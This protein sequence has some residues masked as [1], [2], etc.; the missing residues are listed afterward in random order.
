MGRKIDWSLGL[1]RLVG[2]RAGRRILLC[3]VTAAASLGRGA[4][5]RPERQALDRTGGNCTKE[6]VGRSGALGRLLISSAVVL[7][8][9]PAFAQTSWTNAG[10]GNWFVNGNWSAGTPPVGASTTVGNGGTAQIGAAANASSNLAI[11]NGSTVE[12]D[13]GGSLTASNQITVDAT[14]T[15]LLNGSTAVSTSTP[16]TSFIIISGTLRSTGSGTVSTPSNFT[17]F[18]P[19]A[20]VSVAT[21]Q[22]LNFAPQVFEV[23]SGLVKF[24][25]AT[26]A[27]TI[28][29]SSTAAAA[30][31]PNSSIEVVNGTVKALDSLTLIAITTDMV[32]TKVDVGAVLDLNDSA[33]SGGGF[34]PGIFNLVG[35][36]GQ[37]KI[38]TNA[39]TILNIN[40]GN[41]AGVISGAGGLAVT[42]VGQNGAPDTLILTGN[43]TYAGGV[44]GTT[45]DALFT[46]QLG[47]GGSSGSILGNVI[48]NGMLIFDRSDTYVF[49]G[50]IGGTGQVVQNGTGTTVIS[51]DANGYSGGTVI[52]A[53]TLQF[54]NGGSSGNLPGD[55]LD[56]ATLA[57]DHSN[58]YAYGG[59]ISGTG[60]VTQI[61]S[62]TLTLSGAN[63]YSGGTTVA[64][65]TLSI[66]ADNN[67]GTGPVALLNG[68]TLAF[69][70][71]FTYTHPTT[72]AGMTSLDVAPA[73]VVTISSVLAD[74]GS[75]GELVKI[76][77][78]TLALSGTNTYSGGT[79]VMA[80][81]LSLTNG[82]AI[83]T[84]LLALG[85]GTTLDL[86]GS[87]TLANAVTI[88]GDPLFNVA[89]GNSSTLSGVI[90]DGPAP[91]GVVEKTGGGTLTLTGA[92]TYSGG[93]LI[94][95]GTLVGSSTSFGSGAILDNGALIFNQAVNGSF[96]AK[97][98]GTG[99]VTKEGAGLL[100]LTGM[101]LYTGP[102]T[103]AAGTLVV[104][105][106]IATS[107]VTVEAGATLGGSGTVG[108][109]TVQ[110]GATI[111]PGT[112]TPFTTLNVSGNVAF[113][114]GSAF[115]V[116]VNAAGNSDRLA[117]TGKTTLSGG[118]VQVIAA[119]GV[120]SPST[121]YTILTAAGGVNG[122]FGDLTTTANLAFLSPLLSYDAN[123]VFLGFKQTLTP[124]GTPVPFPSVALTRNQAWTAI[125]I[126]SLGAGNPVYNVVLGQTI[127]GAR[128]AFDALSGEIH[129]SA[130]TA[131]M[132]DSRLPR[133]AIL[134]RLNQP[135]EV[136]A[137]GAASTMT[138][139]YAADLPSGK[140]PVLAPVEVRMYQPRIFGVW[141]QGFGDWGHTGTD[142]NA[143][144]LSRTTGGFVVGADAAQTLW[145]GIFR[146]G[147]AG[148]YT[149]DQLDVKQRLSSG[150]FES[151]FGGIYGGASFGAIQLRAGVLYGANSTSTTRN[152]V[153]PGF[154]DA[155]GSSYGGSTAQAFA[156]A[157]YRIGFADYNISGLGFSRMSLE[158]FV[159]AAAIHIHQNGFAEAGGV[160]ALLG[161][162]RSYDLATTT[163]GLRAE[164]TLA[165]PL[166]LTARALLG[167]RHAFG[168]VVP[169]TVMAFE[170]GGQPFPIAGVRVD[171]DAIVA[172]AGLD[173][174]VSSV[175]TL[176]VSYS[177]QYG[178]RATDNAFKGHLD[179][180]FW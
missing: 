107:P 19:S 136:P 82:S 46:L 98:T 64:S 4:E 73:T 39:V 172:E 167:W 147:L 97:I 94:D 76:D 138:G 165:G 149:N 71:S 135:A 27:G 40:K 6:R 74:G 159:G 120:Y 158:P 103:I 96:G 176:G 9:W 42:A 166:P 68:S 171:R 162:G 31:T 150:S 56:N 2:L 104:D 49:A 89:A 37:V 23:G 28:G 143:A 63:T 131:A 21:G 109:L 86:N 77:G 126:Q 52:N 145:N 124:A 18:G 60:A 14:S 90:S 75:M 110:S 153:F 127:A 116:N 177:G 161:F 57:F 112:V 121:R 123:D 44:N 5:P 108:A 87:F 146:L 170:S 179:V 154:S 47:N 70:S 8:T 157:G 95:A 84:G 93:T 66:S 51:Q 99:S 83:G 115:L 43:N 106:S 92:N 178:R 101:S 148:G 168:D 114:A 54:G 118:V 134:D 13:A 130:V 1:G 139:A 35:A 169:D 59:T 91:P 160:A 80:G 122:T 79:A 117:A 142:H 174:V 78:G 133:E 137:L 25:T 125:G 175:I 61:G 62:G 10:T 173:Y 156:E 180:S 34:P 12:L 129:A 65:G 128:Q 88:T 132:E 24:G 20:V 105:G 100:D 36:G 141:G 155:A 3:G 41:Y 140:G 164:T 26:D 69:T 17:F 50:S 67:L 32:S 22:T 30:T 113:A 152:I 144:S 16:N 111:A 29:V 151:V 58:T 102:T 81:T 45:I 11:S 119:N 33:H 7:L 38:G 53:G 48:D 15:L 163:L 72:L 85:Q 55:V